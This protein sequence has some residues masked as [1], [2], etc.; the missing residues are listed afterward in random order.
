MCCDRAI[1]ENWIVKIIHII[2]CANEQEK[3][4]FFL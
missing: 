1:I 4:L 2:D 3:V